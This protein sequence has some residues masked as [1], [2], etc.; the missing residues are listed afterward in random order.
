MTDACVSSPRR[1][2]RPCLWTSGRPTAM[3]IHTCTG[4]DSK[5]HSN[6]CG[7]MPGR[8]A[9][10]LYIWASESGLATGTGWGTGV[11]ECLEIVNFW[12]AA[13]ALGPGPGGVLCWRW[14]EAWRSHVRISFCVCVSAPAGDAPHTGHMR[15]AGGGR[16]GAAYGIM[17]TSASSPRARATPASSGTP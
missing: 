9:A 4:P 5:A 7:H 6:M 14:W 15:R 11:A 2:G 8:P 17:C 13:D 3:P 1:V 12:A 16:G 10:H